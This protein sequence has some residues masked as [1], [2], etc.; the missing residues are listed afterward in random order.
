MANRKVSEKVPAISLDSVFGDQL[1]EA[2]HHDRYKA[3]IKEM[4]IEHTD[5]VP[6]MKKVQVYSDEQIDKRLF[7][8]SKVMGGLLLT[9][10]ITLVIDF[11]IARATSGH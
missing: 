8:N 10:I 5:S 2:L 6:F 3:K 11:L 4:I 9:W 1:F 7:K